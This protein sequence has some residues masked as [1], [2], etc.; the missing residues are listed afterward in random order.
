MVTESDITILTAARQA[1]DRAIAW[2]E[3]RQHH[4]G[5][6][7]GE[8]RSTDVVHYAIALALSGEMPSSPIIQDICDF[9]ETFS[10]PSGGL[11]DYRA[12]RWADYCPFRL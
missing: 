9:I 5:Q 10:T 2:L 11:G 4:E 1:V 6:W 3:Q 8:Q 12:S 7:L